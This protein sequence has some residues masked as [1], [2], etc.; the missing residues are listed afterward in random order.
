MLGNYLQQTNLAD[1]IFQM[2][3]CLCALGLNTFHLGCLE[4]CTLAK[5]EDPDE[6]PQIAVFHQGLLCL[7]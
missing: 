4:T 6:M 3:F 5:S 7:Q 1:V 2:H